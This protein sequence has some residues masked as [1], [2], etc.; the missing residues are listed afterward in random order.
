MPTR[1]SPPRPEVI[2]F[3]MLSANHVDAGAATDATTAVTTV[4]ATDTAA[5]A[6][7]TTVVAGSPAYTVAQSLSNLAN[8]PIVIPTQAL[9]RAEKAYAVG[10][11]SSEQITQLAK[12]YDCAKIKVATIDAIRAVIGM[13]VSPPSHNTDKAAC[14]AA[15]P[16]IKRMT[17]KRW[18]AKLYG[19]E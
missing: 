11:L 14:E 15:S 17:F 8:A 10:E 2:A 5:V 3:Y 6:T 13:H 4:A 12:T 1:S 9:T 16:T 18:K 7:A 19:P